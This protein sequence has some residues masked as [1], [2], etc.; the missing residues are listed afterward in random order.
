[1][2]DTAYL[3]GLRG[4]RRLV[5]ICGK[6]A[7]VGSG[8]LQ[9]SRGIWKNLPR[10]TVVPTQ[11]QRVLLVEAVCMKMAWSVARLADYTQGIAGELMS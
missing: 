2:T 4:H 7:A 5:A 1:M 8:I 11:Q 10:K 3:V 6:F 9:T